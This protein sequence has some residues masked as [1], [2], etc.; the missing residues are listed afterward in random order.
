MRFLSF[1]AV[2]SMLLAGCIA[3][4][5]ADGRTRDIPVPVRVA[6]N[7]TSPS[8]LQVHTHPFIVEHRADVGFSIA[9]VDGARI[10]VTLVTMDDWPRQEPATGVEWA[11]F[12]N[13]TH[14]AG[15]GTVAPGK[16][17]LRAEC[18]GGK[19]RIT[20]TLDVRQIKAA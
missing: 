14:A 9:G 10:N 3:E 18:V 6:D 20:Y 5:V 2:F 8:S 17:G 7:V 1:L 11:T 19:C 16:W 12:A 13:V 15:N 4:D